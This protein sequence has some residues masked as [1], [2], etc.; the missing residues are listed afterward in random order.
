M[1]CFDLFLLLVGIT[2]V[3]VQG[4]MELPCG[5]TPRIVTESAR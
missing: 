3:A 5:T 1:L 4:M 2:V